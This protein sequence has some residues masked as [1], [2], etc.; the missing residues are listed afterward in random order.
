VRGGQATREASA[1]NIY[2]DDAMAW[3]K[4]Y[5]RAE[6][7]NASDQISVRIGQRATER[8]RSGRY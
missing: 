1:V 7:A 3:L 5:I 8:A 4:P 2:V 6:A